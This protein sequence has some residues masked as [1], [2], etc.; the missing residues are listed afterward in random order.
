MSSI[1]RITN[2]AIRRLA[3]RGG[4]NRMSDLIYEETRGILMLFL[5]NV[6]RHAIIL[7][8]YCRRKTVTTLDVIDALKRQGRTLY[9]FGRRIRRYQKTSQLKLLIDQR[10]FKGLV[11]ELAQDY[12][13]DLRFQGSAV[14]ALQESEE[15]YLVGLF[16]DTNLAAIHAKRVTI[17]TKDMLKGLEKNRP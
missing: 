9:G 5:E 17:M 10:P 3:S 16:E 1:Q 11:R 6:L 14:L 12:K 2:S 13:N 15:A 8:D 7:T 4:V